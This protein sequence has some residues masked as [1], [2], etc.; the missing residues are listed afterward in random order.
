MRRARHGASSTAQRNAGKFINS[1]I[2]SL[3]GSDEGCESADDKMNRRTRAA[4]EPEGKFFVIG[5][6]SQR[7]H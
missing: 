1:F 7:R 4:S 2:L 5:G 3:A 6:C